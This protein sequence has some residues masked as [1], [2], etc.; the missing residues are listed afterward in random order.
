MLDRVVSL[1]FA[2]RSTP[3]GLPLVGRIQQGQR[4][5]ADARPTGISDPSR[6]WELR[7]A[8]NSVPPGV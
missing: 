7:E 1:S 6:S 8:V 2:A 3:A 4:R 5:D